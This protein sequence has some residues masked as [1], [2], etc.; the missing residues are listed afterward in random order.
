MAGAWL[1]LLC[2]APATAQITQDDA[3]HQAVGAPADLHLSG[4]V[5]ARIEVIEDQFRPEAAESDALISLRTT[6]FAE[7]QKGPIRVGAEFQDARGYLQKSNSSADTGVVN[8]LEFSQYYIGFDLG[9]ALGSG[10]ETR[11]TAG[12]QTMALGSSR[13][14]SRQGFRNSMNSYA[15]VRLERATAAGG[16]FVAFW[17]MPNIRLP[18]DTTSILANDPQWDRETTDLQLFGAFNA[19]PIGKGVL[20][21]AYAY[22]L[23]ERDAPGFETSDRRIVTPGLR[24]KRTPEG[25]GIDFEIEAMAQFGTARASRSATDVTDRKVR[26]YGFHGELGYRWAGGL[27]PRV[28]GFLDY[29][30][31][32]R[33]AGA[34][35]RF[36]S[37][38]GGRR[39]EFGP[40]ALFGPVSRANLVSPGVRVEASVGKRLSLMS[41]YRLL[42][43]DSATDSFAATGVRD[44]SGRSGRNA[45]QQ[46]EAQLRYQLVPKIAT[47]E[48]GYARL[49]KGPFLQNAPNAPSTGDTEYAYADITFAF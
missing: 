1:V 18:A 3:L 24:L 20:L 30:T 16:R 28:T 32:D 2:A 27:K 45:G 44:S 43:L 7:Y 4:S 10:S 33:G 40:T 12:R 15:G 29:Y 48:M 41:N 23:A 13:L 46:F 49:F 38:Y 42:W 8:A 22:G 17:M 9:A 5:R 26:A 19:R 36:D 14:V 37:L 31:G 25:T 47:L 11:V 34:L 39:F 6:L 35:N 21:E